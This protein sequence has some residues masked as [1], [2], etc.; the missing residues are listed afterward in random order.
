VNEAITFRVTI[1]G[2]GNLGLFTLPKFKFADE[3]D[4]FPPKENFEKNV[5]RDALSGRMRWDYILIP[6]ISGTISI[7]PITMTYFD[8]VKEKWQRIS[9]RA[10]I[11]PVTKGAENV[12]DNNGLS[13]KE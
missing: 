6:R 1:E 3:L 8:P 9:S 12:F 5:F 13:K 2:T 11:I 10:T 4:Q 7:P